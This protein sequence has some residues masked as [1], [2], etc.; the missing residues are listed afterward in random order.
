MRFRNGGLGAAALAMVLVACAPAPDAGDPTSTTV[1]PTS[2]TVENESGPF[3]FTAETLD[4]GSLAGES[5][6]GRDVVLWFW[7]PWCPICLV[8]GKEEVAPALAELPDDVEFIGIAGRSDDLDEMGEFVEWTGTGAVTHVVDADGSI[9]EAFG[10]A[11]QPAF[12]FVNQ[13][14]TARRA[15]S[16]LNTEDILAEVDILTNS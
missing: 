14:G 2:T 15:G 5:L 7:A 13:D 6:K 3:D 10:I 11:V 4:G 1:P 16:G 12:Y 9:W 8:E